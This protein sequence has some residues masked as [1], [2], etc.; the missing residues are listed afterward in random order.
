MACWRFRFEFAEK[1]KN[2]D[3]KKEDFIK[4]YKTYPFDEI[5]RRLNKSILTDEDL[6]Y[7]RQEKRIMGRG[8]KIW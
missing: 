7:I 1:T 5:A 4:F 2:T 6:K 3:N 8:Q